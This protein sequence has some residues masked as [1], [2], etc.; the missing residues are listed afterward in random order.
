MGTRSQSIISLGQIKDSRVLFPLVNYFNRFDNSIVQKRILQSIYHMQEPRAEDFLKN[1]ISQQKTNSLDIAIEALKV[2]CDNA[3]F[4]YRFN[5]SEEDRREAKQITGQI[6]V[7]NNNLTDAEEILK[8]NTESLQCFKP[9]TY[10]IGE[11]KKMLVGG[12]IN[13]H[14][15]V[16]RGRDVLAAGEIT[17]SK[18]GKNWEV[19]YINH[20]SC[21]Y[22]PA[23]GCFKWVKDFFEQSDVKFMKNR[24][25]EPFPRE[26]YNDPDFLLGFKFGEKYY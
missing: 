21:G 18:E 10:I 15:R 12:E 23:K 5:S 13:E 20:R 24:F 6:E 17:F 2:C 22:F 14:V 11:D 19:D 4:V 7:F 16:A 8:Q 3:N 25:D 1:Y 9:H 26:G